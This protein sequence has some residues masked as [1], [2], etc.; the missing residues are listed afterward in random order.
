MFYFASTAEGLEAFVS[1]S[2]GAIID[3][4]SCSHWIAYSKNLLMA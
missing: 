4:G 3:T 2:F 1:L